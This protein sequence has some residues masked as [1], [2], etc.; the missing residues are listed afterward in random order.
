MT[1]RE[2]IQQLISSAISIHDIADE[3]GVEAMV[4]SGS[5]LDPSNASYRIPPPQWREAFIHL[6]QRRVAKLQLLVEELERDQRTLLGGAAPRDRTVT[7]SC[8]GR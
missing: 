1:F 8:E 7:L 3:A 6:A 4:I 2:A 5:G